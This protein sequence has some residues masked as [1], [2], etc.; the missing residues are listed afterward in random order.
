[1]RVIDYQKVD[2]SDDEFAAYQELVGQLGEEAFKGLIT[3]DARGIITVVRP[4]RVVSWAVVFWC[5]MVMVNQRQRLQ[6]LR[7]DELQRQL[8]LLS[9]KVR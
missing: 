1:M 5:Q 3:T 6:D 2:L 7:I 9:D 4:N 8:E